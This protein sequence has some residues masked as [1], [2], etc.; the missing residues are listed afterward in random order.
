MMRQRRHYMSQSNGLITERY[1]P[2]SMRAHAFHLFS[3]VTLIITGWYMAKQF[4]MCTMDAW[5]SIPYESVRLFHMFAALIFIIAVW[6][7]TI[8]NLLT[9]GHLL[10][11]IFF[12]PDAIQLKNMILSL[13]GKAE[14]PRYV[15]VDQ[16][17]GHY[18]NKL[19]PAI[20]LLVIP[21]N[22]AIVL[23]VA[24][25]VI[26]YA[27]EYAFWSMY[28]EPGILYYIGYISPWFNMSPI[29]FVRTV[30][31]WAM[32]WFIVELA[33]HFGLLG[34]DPRTTKYFNAVFVNGKEEMDKYTEIIRAPHKE[35]PAKKGHHPLVV[36]K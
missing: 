4:N 15:V 16:E 18:K 12:I 9:S 31:L 1:D 25:G 24:T 19:H 30:H 28:I 13:F 6:I 23:I 2:K 27:P 35:K 7:F 8:Y 5:Q 3:C 14:Y 36:L 32:Y 34:M 11:E 22:I 21:E 10:S 20:K 26:M 17:T 29:G 33:L